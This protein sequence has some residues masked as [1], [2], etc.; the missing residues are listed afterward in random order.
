ML[1]RFLDARGDVADRGRGRDA[2]PPARPAGQRAVGPHRRSRRA[3]RTRPSRRWSR[4]LRSN[5]HRLRISTA[6]HAEAERRM[7]DRTAT[8]TFSDGSPSAEL[9]DPDGHDRAGRH[10]HPH[11][12]RQDRQVHLRPRLHVD[13][14]VQLGDHLH[15]RRQGRAPVPRLSDRGARAVHCDFLEVCYLLLYG[16]LP[17]AGAEGQ[18]VAARD[19]AHDGERADAV[20]HAR[21]PPRRASDGGDDRPGRRAVGVLSRTRSTC[22][23]RTSATSR[24]S[25]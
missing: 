8:L 13:G 17:N 18:F 2:R 12:V 3:R 19:Q 24:R 20:L 14:G 9:P 5:V 16:E 10:R 23:T 11:A 22:T 1:T 6:T 15:R 4:A 25:A 7:T 21:L